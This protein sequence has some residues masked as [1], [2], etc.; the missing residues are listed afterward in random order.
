[1][2]KNYTTHFVIPDSQVTPDS[3]TR[4][5]KA[6]GNFIVEHQ[7]DVIVNIGDF[8]DMKSLC[9]YDRDWETKCVV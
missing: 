8:W 5:L 7:P 9:P 4:H 6:A 2:N 1:M 3:P